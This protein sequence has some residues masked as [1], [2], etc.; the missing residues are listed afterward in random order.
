MATVLCT[1][2]DRI[3]IETRNL[4]LRQAGHTAVPAMEEPELVEACTNQKFDVAVIGQAISNSQ[5]Q[6]LFHLVRKYCPSARVLELYA[7][8]SGR[9]LPDADDWLEVPARVPADLAVHVERLAAKS[10]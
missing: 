6:R 8:F 4:I 7:P 10:S 3:L 5:K 1:G 2:A 9:A